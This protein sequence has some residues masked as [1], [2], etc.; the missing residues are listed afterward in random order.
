MSD[1]DYYKTLEINREASA[2]EIRKAY[3]K[4]A[5]KYHP[6]VKP[7]DKAAA[8]KFKQVQEAYAVLGDPEKREQYDRYGSAFQGGGPRSAGGRG[9]GTTYTWS[10]PDG[11]RP[12]DIEE[13]FGGG[14]PFDLGE[15]FGG[16]PGGGSSGGRGRSRSSRSQSAPPPPTRGRS[17]KMQVSVPFE[18]ASLGGN[19]DITFERSG[20]RERL[21]VKIPAAIE[22]GRV[23]RLKQ[24]GEPGSHGG[25]PGDLLL[26]VTVEPHKYF[27]RDGLHLNLNLPITPSEAVLGCRV[28]VPTL[29]EGNVWLTV[30]PGT[31]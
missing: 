25:P 5:R 9:G 8:E 2:D 1:I 11:S 15:I 29:H 10:G 31:R 20:K 12:F 7:D 23:M 21:S 13:L 18:L 16:A 27:K 3:R 17:I 28:E 4:Q 24:Q 30:P 14:V 22:S 6:D 19:Q 26:T